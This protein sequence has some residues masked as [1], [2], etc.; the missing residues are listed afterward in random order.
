MIPL[1]VVNPTIFVSPK[2]SRGDTGDKLPIPT[3]AVVDN[4]P[5]FAIQPS[6]AIATMFC[7]PE[8][9]PTNLVAVKTPDTASIFIVPAVMTPVTTDPVKLAIPVI[10]ALPRTS[11]NFSG[12]VV[13]LRY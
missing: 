4:D 1:S 13:Y 5:V 2:T 12:L 8:A 7:K 6:V 3:F 11:R 9:S 10:L